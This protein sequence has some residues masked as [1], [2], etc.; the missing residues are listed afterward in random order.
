[1]PIASVATGTPAGIC[2]IESRESSPFSARLSTGTPSTGSVVCAAVIPGRWAAPPAPAMITSIPRPSAP[3][4]ASAISSGVRCADTTRH[5]WGTPN[6]FNISL[7]ALIVSQSD[8]LPMM[9]DTIGVGDGAGS[10]DAALLTA[11]RE[12]E[13][14][15]TIGH[16]TSAYQR[17]AAKAENSAAC[18]ASCGA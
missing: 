16:H 8:L 7:A 1:M 18:L 2:T 4:A 3:A 9:M 5:S 15:L 12:R 6:S 14:L 11:L 13:S 10:D 17:A